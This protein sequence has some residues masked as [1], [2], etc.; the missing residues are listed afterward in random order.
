MS[1]APFLAR[2]VVSFPDPTRTV[3]PSASREEGLALFEP[4]LGLAES[5]V[6]MT[7]GGARAWP[8]ITA[9]KWTSID[10]ESRAYRV[11]RLIRLAPISI[12]QARLHLI[13]RVKTAKFIK[14]DPALEKF[15]NIPNIWFVVYKKS[16]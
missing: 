7:F 12:L 3:P 10:I 8:E 4:F 2:E 14:F 15:S 13:K 9:K 5:T 1:P 11:Y 6:M 16:H